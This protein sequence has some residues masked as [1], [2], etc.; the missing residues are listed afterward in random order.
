MAAQQWHLFET[1]TPWPRS[2]KA[3]ICRNRHGGDACSADAHDRIAN[4]KE[5]VRLEILKFAREQGSAGITADE[6]AERFH[7]AHNHTS[8]RISELLLEGRLVRTQRRRPT[9]TGCLARVLVVREEIQKMPNAPWFKFFA[10]DRSC[11]E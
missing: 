11:C 4:N 2:M 10:S 6:T 8:P 5:V 7:C 3:D 1:P 9:R